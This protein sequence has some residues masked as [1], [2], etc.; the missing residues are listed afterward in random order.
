MFGWHIVD[1]KIIKE[2]VEVGTLIQL[3]DLEEIGHYRLG[4]KEQLFVVIIMQKQISLL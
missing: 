2:Q 4:Q 1:G 3:Q